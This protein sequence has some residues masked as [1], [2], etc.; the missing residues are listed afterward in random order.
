MALFSP[1]AC[2]QTT[3]GFRI[4]ANRAV[5]ATD[6]VSTAPPE[7]VLGLV[8]GSFIR[9]ALRDEF[10][11]QVEALYS[12]KGAQLGTEGEGS[13]ELDLQVV[14]L[15]VPVL[16]SY[17]IPFTGS[18]RPSLHVGPSIAFELSERVQQ[19]LG[20][21]SQSQAVNELTSPDLGIVVGG[22]VHFEVGGLDALAGLRYTHGLRN[23]AEVTQSESAEV[24]TRTLALTLG[25]LF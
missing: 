14:Y 23:I 22:E 20:G 13:P 5:L 24:R 25:F 10:A 1:E 6:P 18:V 11:L 19:T 2:S 7:P 9:L 3:Y 12:V 21:F 17:A 16:I 15:E 4:G 8:A